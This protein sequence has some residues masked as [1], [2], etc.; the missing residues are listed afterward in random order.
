[1]E[2]MHKTGSLKNLEN[3]RLMS[4]ALLQG[5]TYGSMRQQVHTMRAKR[6]ELTKRL[7]AAR[8]QASRATVT[9]SRMQILLNEEKAA[10]HS[11][12]QAKTHVTLQQAGDNA[13]EE[14]ADRTRAV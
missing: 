7:E 4:R 13:L 8:G 10:K 2:A 12:G 11:P 1:M 5:E 6:V 3:Q 14:E 9:T